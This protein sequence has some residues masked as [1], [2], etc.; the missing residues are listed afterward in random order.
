PVL[1]LLGLPHRRQSGYA[2]AVPGDFALR[3]LFC[4]AAR[5]AALAGLVLPA[6]GPFGPAAGNPQ[7]A[8]V[9]GGS[10]Q[11]VQTSPSRLD[12]N[13]TSNRAVIDWKS[14]SIGTGEQTNFVQPSATSLAVNRVTGDQ[15]STIAGRLNANGQVV[16][17]NPNGILI[18]RNSR[19]DAAG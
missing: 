3:R 14:F 15:A 9:M 8:V 5:L 17:A 11:I 7:G 12:I 16:L 1:T 18:E 6:T 2:R 10:A 13:Q 4:C 19:I